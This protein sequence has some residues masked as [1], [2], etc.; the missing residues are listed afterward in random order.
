MN[1]RIYQWTVSWREEKYF[2]NVW[3]CSYV[4]HWRFC[5]SW[6]L[7]VLVFVTVVVAQLLTHGQLF[8]DHMGCSPPGSSVHGFLQARILEWVAISSFRGSSWPGDWT[9]S[10]VS[11]ALACRFFTTV[12]PCAEA[13]T[14]ACI[15][16]V[17]FEELPEESGGKDK[18]EGSR[19]EGK[20]MHLQY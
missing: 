13:E 11:P 2:S 1:K 15:E 12:P 5:D 16:V 14:R 20:P 9:M 8:W 6:N 10:P 17:Y 3:T 7:P 4:P 19:E 18:E